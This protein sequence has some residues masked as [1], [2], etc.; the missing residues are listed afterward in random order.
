ALG[1]RLQTVTVRIHPYPPEGPR[2]SGVACEARRGPSTILSTLR[3]YS[4]I[5]TFYF[6]FQLSELFFVPHS[7]SS[8]IHMTTERIRTISFKQRQ[9]CRRKRLWRSNNSERRKIRRNKLLLIAGDHP[10][11]KLVSEHNL[12][13]LLHEVN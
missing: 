12:F 13:P 1:G 9:G 11:P 8:G 3:G 2:P 4:D 5:L 7:D 6:C 10:T